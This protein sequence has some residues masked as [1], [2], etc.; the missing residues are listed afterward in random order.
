MTVAPAWFDA[1]R[2]LAMGIVLAGTGIGG[3]IW[4]PASIVLRWEPS[5]EARLRA[6]RVAIII[7]KALY[8]CSLASRG[9]VLTM[10]FAVQELG[11]FIQ[12]QL[13]LRRC[14]S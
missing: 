12:A 11:A 8:R 1:L 9:T 13:T 10:R 3:L 6:E 2:G 7:A 4:T 5:I 14:S